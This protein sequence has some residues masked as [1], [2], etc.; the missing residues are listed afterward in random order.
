MNRLALYK[1]ILINFNPY[2]NLFMVYNK[3]LKRW[4]R[5]VLL[6]AYFMTISLV[7]GVNQA[8]LSFSLS[9]LDTY[10]LIGL[11][12]IAAVIIIFIRPWTITFFYKLLYEPDSKVQD[13]YNV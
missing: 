1:K 11:F 8:L 4:V 9:E 2:L 12:S 6:Q 7:F 13:L 3:F 5:S 10:A